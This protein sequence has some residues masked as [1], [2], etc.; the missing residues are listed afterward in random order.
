MTLL[1]HSDILPKNPIEAPSPLQ[2]ALSTFMGTTLEF[3]QFCN[4]QFNAETSFKGVQRR[5]AGMLSDWFGL[6]EVSYLTLETARAGAE[7]KRGLTRFPPVPPIADGAIGSVRS[8]LQAVVTG[9]DEVRQGFYTIF[10]AGADYLCAQFDEPASQRGVLVWRLTDGAKLTRGVLVVSDAPAPMDILDYIVRSAQRASHWLRRLDSTQALLYQ[11]EVTGLYNYR[12]LDVALD[13]EIKRHQRFHLPFSLLFIDL[14]NFKQ[15]NDIHGH[16]T[17][18][19]V[20]QQAGEQIKAAV[21]DVDSVIR[22]G[23]DEFV[24]VLLG[25]NSRQAW[26]AAERVRGRVDA[27]RFNVDGKDVKVHITTSIG[28]ACCPE[29]ARDKSTIIR[30]ADETMYAAKKGGKNR[31]IMVQGKDPSPT[32]TIR[33]EIP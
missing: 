6:E 15:V 11:D 27:S 10:A 1:T 9:E 7:M 21:R 19:S 23:G 25:A 14:D 20:L 26:M 32:P 31:V 18:S 28:V 8:A 29:H 33:R 16:L 4:D 13:A 17:G 2:G 3:A 5:L 24:V 30:L 22:Y 12:Y